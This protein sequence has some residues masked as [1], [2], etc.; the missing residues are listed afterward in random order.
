MSE[1]WDQR[2]IWID[3]IG[4]EYRAIHP[5]PAH[6]VR[7][8]PHDPAAAELSRLRAEVE[9]LNKERDQ[10]RNDCLDANQSELMLRKRAE[11]AEAAL[12]AERRHADALAE[13]VADQIETENEFW[14]VWDEHAAQAMQQ[15]RAG[16]RVNLHH[17]THMLTLCHGQGEPHDQTRPAPNDLPQKPACASR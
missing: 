1:E 4:S 6:W 7:Y 3:P 14:T 8:V 11:K 12:A 17:A 5:V 16:V 13:L 9:R 15:H 2:P 10:W